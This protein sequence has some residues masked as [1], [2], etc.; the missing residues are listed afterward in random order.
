M[1]YPLFRRSHARP[2]SPAGREPRGVAVPAFRDLPAVLVADTLSA[3]GTS[4]AWPPAARTSPRP[5]QGRSWPP[6]VADSGQHHAGKVLLIIN[7]SALVRVRLWA[8]RGAVRL[9]ASRRPAA[10]GEA[11]SSPL[12]LQA[13]T[14]PRNPDPRPIPGRSGVEHPSWGR[15][16]YHTLAQLRLDPALLLFRRACSESGFRCHQVPPPAPR[17]SAARDPRRPQPVLSHFIPLSSTPLHPISMFF[18][19]ASP[20]SLLPPFLLRDPSGQSVGRLVRKGIT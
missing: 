14:R 3:C 13:L 20:H 12:Q 17:L 18:A 4:P 10:D 16:R 7:L 11:M 19:I 9:A 15:E 6:V 1:A 8:G 2:L 5:A